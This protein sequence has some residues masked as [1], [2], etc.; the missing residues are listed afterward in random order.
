MDKLLEDNNLVTLESPTTISYE[1]ML[2]GEEMYN[3]TVQMMSEKKLITDE[4]LIDVHEDNKK[5]FFR[6]LEDNDSDESDEYQPDVNKSKEKNYIS[7][8]YKIKVVNIVK[9]YPKWSLANLQKKGCS[10][11][12]SIKDLKKWKEHIKKRGTIIDKYATI[13]SWTYDCFMEARENLQQATTR[14]LQQKIKKKAAHE[15]IRSSERAFTKQKLQPFS[16]ADASKPFTATP[17]DALNTI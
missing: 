2:I 1:S 7:L 4:E 15:K 14:N 6:D 9:Q 13:D 5:D 17:K 10:R 8:D 3:N 12:K 16:H 11:L